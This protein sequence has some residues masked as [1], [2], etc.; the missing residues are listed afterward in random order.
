MIR[1]EALGLQKGKAVWIIEI[2][3]PVSRVLY[4][5]WLYLYRTVQTKKWPAPADAGTGQR[6]IAMED[7]DAVEIFHS[8]RW[9]N[10]NDWRSDDPFSVRHGWIDRSYKSQEPG[11]PPIRHLKD[12]RW[13]LENLGPAED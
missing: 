2:T 1:S 3:L 5:N 6:I 11:G 7:I 4:P 12:E 10:I 13:Y 8:G 9:N